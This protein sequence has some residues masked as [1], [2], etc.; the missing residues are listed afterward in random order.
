VTKPVYSTAK[1]SAKEAVKNA[2]KGKYYSLTGKT[3]SSTTT[4]SA[5]DSIP[6]SS[7]AFKSRLGKAAPGAVIA[8]GGLFFEMDSAGSFGWD[9]SAADAFGPAPELDQCMKDASPP[10]I[11]DA[12]S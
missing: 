5:V 3:F 10:W 8:L 1:T 7:G 2:I 9:D 6:V 4:S 11:E 12:F